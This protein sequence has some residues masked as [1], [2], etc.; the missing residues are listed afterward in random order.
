MSHRDTQVTLCCAVRE[1]EF[2]ARDEEVFH[3][4]FYALNRVFSFGSL[5]DLM[6]SEGVPFRL[7]L[8]VVIGI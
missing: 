1:I 3:R 8:L 6:D 2:A 7:A 4:K 5:S